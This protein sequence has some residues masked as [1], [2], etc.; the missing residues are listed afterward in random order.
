V[1]ERGYGFTP[2]D[3]GNLAGKAGQKHEL[4]MLE[5]GVRDFDPAVYPIGKEDFDCAFEVVK[6]S[7]LQDINL[8]PPTVRWDDIGGQ[9]DVKKK[10]RAMVESIKVCFSRLSVSPSFPFVP[11]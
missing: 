7:G 2:R 11:N 4:R 3:L 10:L 8:R 1:A 6:P 9:E 5:A